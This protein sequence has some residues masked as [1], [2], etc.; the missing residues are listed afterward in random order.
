MPTQYIDQGTAHFNNATCIIAH[1]NHRV[2][3]WLHGV[4]HA[5]PE[6][7]TRTSLASERLTEAER[8]RVLYT[9]ITSGP[10]DG[11][12]GITPKRGEWKEVES[13]F[14]LHDHAFNKDWIKRWSSSYV[15]NLEDQDQIRNR[16]GEKVS[17]SIPIVRSV[18]LT[19]FPQIA[20][21]FT[22]LQTYLIF[23][24]FPAAFG[25]AAW[26]LLGNFSSIYAVASCIWSVVFIE[27]WRKQETDL[28]IRWACSGVSAI[29]AKRTEFEPTRERRDPVTGETIKD[30]P[31]MT[32]LARQLLQIP[33]ALLASL[34]LGGLIA[35]CFGIEIFISE[36][37]SGPLKSVL[38]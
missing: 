22:F 13:I 3:D 10:D 18:W 32:R 6:K 15:V 19:K 23:L 5:A 16:F 28:R 29:Q 21:Y 4:R 35:I 30:F 34:A 14:P 27:Y 17:R 9:S 25:F 24:V 37:Y 20:F 11:G 36:V 2:Q 1:E 26:V 7:E 8:L 33:F 38:V 31:K 12:A